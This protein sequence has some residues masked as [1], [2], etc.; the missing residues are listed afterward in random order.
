MLV[1]VNAV[2]PQ[3]ARLVD[4]LDALHLQREADGADADCVA[5]FEKARLVSRQALAVGKGAVA[6]AEVLDRVAVARARDPC[7]MARDGGMI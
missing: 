7:V 4:L 5:A 1:E 6:G 3:V 2:Q